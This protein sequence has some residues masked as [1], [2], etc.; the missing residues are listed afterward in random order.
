M[1]NESEERTLLRNWL[2]LAT[3][4]TDAENRGITWESMTVATRAFFAYP[5]PVEAAPSTIHGLPVFEE[6]E[7]GRAVEASRTPVETADENT[8]S[9][10]G[11][12]LIGRPRMCAI[13]GQTGVRPPSPEAVEPPLT[14]VIE[15][16]FPDD[17]GSWT[18]IARDGVEQAEA[19]AVACSF[20]GQRVREDLDGPGSY[21]ATRT[22]PDYWEFVKAKPVES[23]QE[24][25]VDNARQE[26][27]KAAAE[28]TVAAL[29]GPHGAVHEPEYLA[30]LAALDTYAATVSR[31]AE[32]RARA[33]MYHPDEVR[34]IL[35]RREAA[36]E[37][38]TQAEGQREA[39]FEAA[40]YLFEGYDWIGTGSWQGGQEEEQRFLDENPVFAVRR[41]LSPSTEAPSEEK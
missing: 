20:A 30:L 24:G 38:A 39:M 15:V 19:E 10:C 1:T 7:D 29:N 4:R 25:S 13:H 14:P 31:D 2:R 28:I 21:V 17:E 41:A 11:E 26:V 34:Q 12:A 22:Q 5:P 33:A 18:V 6:S 37:R 23:S 27:I 3:D 40:N 32:E 8:C 16:V 9:R 35:L 36:E